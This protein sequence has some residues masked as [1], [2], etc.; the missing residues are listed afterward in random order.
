MRS[1]HYLLCFH[2]I[3]PFQNSQFLLPFCYPKIMKNRALHRVA[4]NP[5][6][7]RPWA[8]KWSPPGS[9]WSSKDTVERPRGAQTRIKIRHELKSWVQAGPR[10]AKSTPKLQKVS[11][12]QPWAP[13]SHRNVRK[14]SAK[15]LR[16]VL[17]KIAVVTPLRGLSRER[18]TVQVCSS[19]ARLA[20]CG[21]WMAHSVRT[22]PMW[23]RPK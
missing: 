21:L 18:F 7:V 11:Q 12:A 1:V 5:S 23:A 8:A 16:A 13:K 20:A 17:N 4:R 3:G 19:Y 10:V 6:K 22:K 9:T 14:I 15:L 2:H